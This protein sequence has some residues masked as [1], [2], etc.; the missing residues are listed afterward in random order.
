MELI[1][2]KEK[3]LEVLRDSEYY[4]ANPAICEQHKRSIDAVDMQSVANGLA[5]L[6]ELGKNIRATP[7]EIESE[8][9]LLSSVVVHER[10]INRLSTDA[11][12]VVLLLHSE[13]AKTSAGTGVISVDDKERIIMSV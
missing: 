4:K 7:E 1:F 3:M 5:A 6:I 2:T 10:T 8:K 13:L 9:L 11:K 12:V